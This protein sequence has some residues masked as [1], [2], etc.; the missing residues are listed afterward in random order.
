MKTA[1]E[2][3][4][5]PGMDRSVAF[6]R[7]DVTATVNGFSSTQEVSWQLANCSLRPGEEYELRSMGGGGHPCVGAARSTSTST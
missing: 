4:S 3:G 6:S 1:I 7:A 2:F 5:Y